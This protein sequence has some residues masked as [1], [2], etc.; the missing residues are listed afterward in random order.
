LDQKFKLQETQLNE[1][2]KSVQERE[3]IWEKE[4]TEVLE[5]VQNLKVGALQLVTKLALEYEQEGSDTDKRRSLSQEVF[6]L[7][8]IVGMK[9]DEMRN[10]REQVAITEQKLEQSENSEKK[11][12]T[13]LARI[14][15]LEEQVVIKER[16]Q[17]QLLFE[18]S[19]LEIS[20]LDASK[21]VTRLSQNVEEL[22]RT[23]S[24]NSLGHKTSSTSI[25]EVTNT[26]LN[27]PT[28]NKVENFINVLTDVTENADEGGKKSEYDEHE[29][30]NKYC[31][32]KKYSSVTY[33][34]IESFD[35]GLG[36]ISGESEMANSP[37]GC[38]EDR[39]SCEGLKQKIKHP[40]TLCRVSIET[41]L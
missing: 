13:V 38:D 27:L 41:P 5:E 3:D 6:C 40:H 25:D 20:V 2:I 37:T 8:I 22:Q 1:S 31:D 32:L 10:L 19:Q 18:K 36:D 14:E 15:D 23:T 7:Q 35:E 33:P 26:V 34:T 17:K 30:T 12:S 16:A 11:L 39:N 21:A 4:K 29:N 24:R 9:T 28:D